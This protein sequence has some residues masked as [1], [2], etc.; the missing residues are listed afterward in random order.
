MAAV[1][2]SHADGG[3]GR[4]VDRDDL[5]LTSE[6]PT[7]R[8][9]LLGGQLS[10]LEHADP[11]I[12]L[13]SGE[14]SLEADLPDLGLGRLHRALGWHSERSDEQGRTAQ[15]EGELLGEMTH[16]ATNFRSTGR[17]VPWYRQS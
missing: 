9:D 1:G 2:C 4:V 8:V 12:G 3:I 5:D 11:D 14:R 17:R 6:H 7:G 10:T 13:A 15:G 16:R